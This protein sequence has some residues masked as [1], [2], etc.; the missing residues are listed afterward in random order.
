MNEIVNHQREFFK[1]GQT[2]NL[3]F[4]KSQL[5][6]LKNALQTHEQQFLD[7]I[8]SDFKKGPFDAYATEFALIFHE[9]ELALKNL[10]KWSKPQKVKTNIP[11]QPGRSYII[12]EPYG[13]VLV[14]GAWNYPYQLSLVPAISALAAGNTVIIKP[15][16]LAANTSKV[17]AQVLNQVFDPKVLSVQEGGVAE[18]TQLLEQRFDKIFFTGSSPVGKIVYQA[19]AKNLTP[20][21]LELGGKSPAFILPDTDIEVT[22]RRLVWGKFLNAGQTCVAPD[23]LLVHEKIQEQLLDAMAKYLVKFFGSDAQK[24]GSYVRIINTR[25][26]DRLTALIDNNKVAMGGKTDRDDLYIEPTV[27]RDVSFDDPVMQDEIFGPILPIIPFTSLPDAIEMVKDR[28][29]PL[30]LYIFSKN[31]F[32]I[33][34]IVH[35]LSFGGGCINDTIMHLANSYLPFGGVGNSGM[36]NYHGKF[37]FDGFSHQK[38][39]LRKGFSF[40]PAIKYPPY[41][42]EKLAWLKRV[43][44][45]S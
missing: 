22:A 2:K 5:L 12:P 25:N 17:M 31:E 34:S 15:S 43:M 38:S 7:A 45:I 26:F 44:S 10:K 21:T 13:T 37:G 28:E 29:K 19:A 33:D 23:Y 27:L 40:E 41:S 39:L 8:D 20:V 42:L 4:R 1:T 24:S 16:E 32:D 6:T 18:T 35:Q 36:G 3:M 30:A 11:N 9:I 14:I